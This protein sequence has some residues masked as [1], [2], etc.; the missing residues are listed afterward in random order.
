MLLYITD[1][2]RDAL[3]KNTVDTIGALVS[4]CPARLLLSLKCSN[5]CTFSDCL[6]GQAAAKPARLDW[7]NML[8]LAWVCKTSVGVD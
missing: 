8:H 1:M 4:T 5:R 6:L 7:I 2:R 3:F